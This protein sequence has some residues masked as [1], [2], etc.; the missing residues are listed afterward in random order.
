MDLSLDFA[1][2]YGYKSRS[3]RSRVVTE[4]WVEQEMY[5]PSCD[6]SELERLPHGTKVIDFRCPECSE[7]FQLKSSSKSMGHKVMD[8]EY[9]TMMRAI[10]SNRSP[11]LIL[12]HYSTDVLQVQDLLLI[13]RQL[14][15]PSTIE[16]RNPLGL[17]TR[18]A[19][20]TGCKILLQNIPSTAQLFAVRTFRVREPDEI[21]EEWK[22]LAF[23]KEIGPE[24]R[25]WVVDVLRCIQ[26]LE[27]KQF[28][29]REMYNRFEQELSKLHPQNKHVRPK[30]RQQLQILRDKGII[31]FVGE[32]IYEIR[33]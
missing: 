12:M 23:V 16:K 24:A 17:T 26:S 29:L 21:R 10:E 15:V 30:I 2:G 28:T 33:D 20:W 25:G 5:C 8:S 6:S 27:K 7:P 31:R 14:I 4:A 22:R 9:N 1:K 13:P 32:G 11:N 3:Q 19:G 18:R